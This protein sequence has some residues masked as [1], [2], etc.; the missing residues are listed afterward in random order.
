MAYLAY[1]D[2]MA[3]SDYM[4]YL[5]CMIWAI[6]RRFQIDH[7]AIAI[8]MPAKIIV[9]GSGTITSSTT[10]P[11]VTVP[12]AKLAEATVCDDIATPVMLG[13][14]PKYSANV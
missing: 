11:L 14:N 1:L 10:W 12:V 3:Y 8:P 4:A 5:A 7:P 9:S 6:R 13:T 2:Y